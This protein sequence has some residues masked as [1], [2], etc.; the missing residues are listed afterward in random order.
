M[1]AENKK[2]NLL[3]FMQNKSHEMGMF[4]KKILHVNLTGGT[5]LRFY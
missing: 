3:I 1:N 5:V 2:S 4:P